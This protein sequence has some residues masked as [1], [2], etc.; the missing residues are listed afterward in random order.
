[1]KECGADV[2]QAQNDGGTPL[3]VTP[4]MVAACLGH[5]KVVKFLGR[6]PRTL[7]DAA[8]QFNDVRYTAKTLAADEKL[9]QWLDRPCSRPGCGHRGKKKCARCQLARCCSREC[10]VAHWKAGHK[11]DCVR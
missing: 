2:N 3:M 6:L 9:S 4:L 8:V 1:M 10:Q 7:I 5:S 11:S